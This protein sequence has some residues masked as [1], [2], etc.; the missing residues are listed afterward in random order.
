M[1]INEIRKQGDDLISAAAK[2]VA[3]DYDKELY[4][5][6]VGTEHTKSTKIEEEDEW[7]NKN[8]GFTKT[9]RGEK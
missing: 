7:D 4:E 6:M 3:D 2:V 1:N 5:A 8:I 9:S